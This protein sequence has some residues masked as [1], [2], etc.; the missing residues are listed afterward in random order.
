MEVEQTTDTKEDKGST[1]EEGKCFNDY[2]YLQALHFL[3]QL[4]L[5]SNKT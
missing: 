3:N 1:G 5:F 4:P 2:Q